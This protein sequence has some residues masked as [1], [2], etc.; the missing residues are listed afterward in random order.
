MS[1]PQTKPA[2][3][4]AH[5]SEDAERAVASGIS[6]PNKKQAPSSLQ[7]INQKIND[8]CFVCGADN[9][10]GLHAQFVQSAAPGVVDA[11]F[12][13]KEIH[14]SYPGRLH[15]GVAAAICD[16]TIGRAFLT[17]HEDAWGVT[18]TMNLRYK[19]PT[20]LY[21]DLICRG[22]ITRETNRTFEGKAELMTADRTVCVHAEATYM[23][24][25]VDTIIAQGN[26]KDGDTSYVWEEDMRP[27]PKGYVAS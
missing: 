8:M 25:S 10:A 14:M 18:M 11:F 19:K 21:E 16:E 27:L 2:G 7:A 26:Q 15:G 5:D 4:H 23:K 9:P 24:L 6:N 12:S 1:K 17:N 13:G 22:E 20:P 3:Y